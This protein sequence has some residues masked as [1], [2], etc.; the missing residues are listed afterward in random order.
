MVTSVSKPTIYKPLQLYK[1]PHQY[2]NHIHPSLT[3]VC[4]SWP[5]PPLKAKTTTQQLFPFSTFF[6]IFRSHEPP[7]LIMPLLFSFL[8]L[9][10]VLLQMFLRWCQ[11]RHKRLPPGSMGWPYI[12]ETIKLYTENPNSFFSNRQKRYISPQNIHEPT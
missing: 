12:G 1:S 3:I 8:L 2:Q 10:L 6:A 7:I 9:L 5:L 4:S 11:P